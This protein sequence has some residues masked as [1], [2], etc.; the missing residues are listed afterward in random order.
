MPQMFAEFPHWQFYSYTKVR[1]KVR[2]FISGSLPDNYHITYSWNER[3]SFDFVRDLL[4][5]GVNTAVPFF[6]AATLRPTIP[7]FWN[8]ETVIDGDKS[9]LRFLD[10]R[11]VIV[12]LSVKLP[13]LRKLANEQVSKSEGFFVG[14]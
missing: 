1:G 5:D 13:K 6:D 11:G 10:P 14:I 8:G 4:W 7:K 9:D 3:A 12:G 2:Q